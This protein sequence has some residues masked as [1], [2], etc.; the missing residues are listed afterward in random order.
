MSTIPAQRIH[1][2]DTL[3]AIGLFFVVLGHTEGISEWLR[4]YIYSFH[5]PLFF[6][7]TGY[8]V[9]IESLRGDLSSFILKYF[10]TLIHPYFYFGI[11]TYLIWLCIGRFYGRDILLAVPPLKPLVGMIYG[12]SINHWLRHNV[13]LWFLPSLFC[14]HLIFYGLN[15]FF[16]G[17]CQVYSVIA[18][19][20]MGW[21]VCRLLPFRLPWG[22]EPAC[23]SIFFY[24]TGYLLHRLAFNPKR[25]GIAGR[26]FMLSTTLSIHVCG[27]TVNGGVDVNHMF[28]GNL[29]AFYLTAFSG[30]AFWLLISDTLPPTRLAATM[31]RGSMIIFSFHSLSLSVFTF[32]A[33]T[34]YWLT[35]DFQHGALLSSGIQ[36][37]MTVTLL[38][39]LSPWIKKAYRLPG[40]E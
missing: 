5:I 4:M 3:K 40:H 35:F 12:T 34:N 7:I 36:S 24:A 9:N 13:A 18:V 1:W 11:T 37:A 30:I 14:L 10:R 33:K 21:A 8:L 23:I 28:L 38:A 19:G 27:L 25:I 22:I 16:D 6:F 2:L 32:A 31:A 20:L 17:L 29:A 26:C 15:R 39:A